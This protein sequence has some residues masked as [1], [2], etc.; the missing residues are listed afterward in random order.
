MPGLA[1]MLS[2][3]GGLVTAGT[4]LFVAAIAFAIALV[5]RRV[6]HD[7]AEAMGRAAPSGFAALT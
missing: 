3:P 2:L 7:H 5:L 1:E 6:I 4:S